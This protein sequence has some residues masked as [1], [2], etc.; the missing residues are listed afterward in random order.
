MLAG[1]R[2]GDHS[3]LAEPFCQQRLA[4]AIV[5]LVRTG[6]IQI[7]A[8]EIDLRAAEL[9]GPALGVIDRARPADIMLELRFE[10]GD[11]GW[12]VLI[13]R[14]LFSKLVERGDKRLGDKHA[15]VGAEVSARIRQIIH[16]HCAPPG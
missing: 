10:F 13:A 14:V 11:E 16:L 8:L 12:I 2:L 5:Y 4:D 9:F 7:L 15:A 1:A 6:V 3:R